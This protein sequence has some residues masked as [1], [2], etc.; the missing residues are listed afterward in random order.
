MENDEKERK[1]LYDK[2]FEEKRLEVRMKELE[3]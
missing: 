1:C 3:L 2:D